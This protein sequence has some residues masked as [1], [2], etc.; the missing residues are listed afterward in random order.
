MSRTVLIPTVSRR[1]M[2]V[3]KMMSALIIATVVIAVAA[4]VLILADTVIQGLPVINLDFLTN[5]PRP[6]GISGGGIGPDIVGTFT[7]VGLALVNRC[8]NR[9]WSWCI[10]LRVARVETIVCL[11]FHK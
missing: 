3:D 9:H 10:L 7:M 1:R 8:T 4:L 11:Q 5:T 2:I 6:V